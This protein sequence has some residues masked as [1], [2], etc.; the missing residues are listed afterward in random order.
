MK[1]QESSAVEAFSALSQE[2][3]LRMLRALVRA[4]PKGLSAGDVGKKVL[5][6][7]SNASFHLAHLQ[8]A[9]LVSS[10]REARSIIYVAEFNMITA[11]A[12][13]LLEDCCSG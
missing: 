1:T 7:A 6:A 12:N 13:F 8:R 9:G 10:R 2:T 5:V 3:R 11:L 4:G